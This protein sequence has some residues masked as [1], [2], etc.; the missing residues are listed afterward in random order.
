MAHHQGFSI[1]LNIR[2]FTAMEYVWLVVAWILYFLHHSFFAASEVKTFL[3]NKAGMNEQVQR[4]LYSLVATLGLLALLFFNGAVSSDYILPQT[5]FF[6]VFGVFLAAMGVFIARE[7]FK[8]Y[9]LTTFLGFKAVEKEEF[10]ADGILKH[11]RHPLYS[12]TILLVIGFFIYD[13]RWPTLTSVICIIAYLPVGIYLEE[14]KMGAL[15]GREYQEYKKNT[16][17]FIPRLGK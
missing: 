16:P 5:R 17:M 3:K 10:I 1:A 13:A 14:K 12:A 8:S 4:L 9:S 7:A 2:I 15:F 6:K 11:I